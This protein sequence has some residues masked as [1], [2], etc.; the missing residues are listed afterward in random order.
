MFFEIITQNTTSFPGLFSATLPLAKKS[1]E[2]EVVQSKLEMSKLL[3]NK[4]TT[5][6]DNRFD[7]HKEQF[8]APRTCI[9][10]T[11]ACE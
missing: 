5:M 1:P 2:N 11:K 6:V 7:E 10:L 8:H 3:G 4:A 9:R